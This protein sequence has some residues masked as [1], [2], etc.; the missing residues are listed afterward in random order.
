MGGSGMEETSSLH[1][2][3]MSFWGGERRGECLGHVWKQKP[4]KNILV[5]AIFFLPEQAPCS[6]V[7][8][9]PHVLSEDSELETAAAAHIS[10]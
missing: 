9:L 7:Q 5:E 10:F 2:K 1:F 6:D 4:E 3:D 8:L